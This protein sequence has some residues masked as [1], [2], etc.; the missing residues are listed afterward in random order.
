MCHDLSLDVAPTVATAF[1]H[2]HDCRIL[3]FVSNLS[4]PQVFLP[5]GPARRCITIDL[6]AE[7]HYMSTVPIRDVANEGAGS[8]SAAQGQDEGELSAGNAAQLD[9]ADDPDD[10]V[11]SN[12]CNLASCTPGNDMLLCDWPHCN[13][14]VHLACLKPPLTEVPEG[15]WYCPSCADKIF[16]LT[17]DLTKNDYTDWIHRNNLPNHLSKKVSCEVG[18]SQ[19]RQRYEGEFILPK[20]DEYQRHI[21]SMESRDGQQGRL[22]LL[23]INLPYWIAWSDQSA[24]LID[25]QQ[26]Q[27]FLQQA[28][29]PSGLP[30]RNRIRNPRDDVPVVHPS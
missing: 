27:R 30:R 23:N 24:Q 2:L 8:V 6:A 16:R 11:R 7:M 5:D 29:P 26:A 3:L 4:Q 18:S 19:N 14:A 22:H 20:Y 15:D 9:S 25:P 17:A 10:L 12:E 1:A 28:N 21:Q 13:N